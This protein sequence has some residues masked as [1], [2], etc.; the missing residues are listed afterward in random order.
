LLIHFRDGAG[1][2]N[3]S[4]EFNSQYIYNEEKDYYKLHSIAV[5]DIKA[6]E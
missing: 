2:L 6:G 3:H 5:R 1:Y 4:L